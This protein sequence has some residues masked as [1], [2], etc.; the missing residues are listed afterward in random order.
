MKLLLLLIGG[1][2]FMNQTSFSD[3]KIYTELD[4][5]K[6]TNEQLAE[7]FI[8]QMEKSDDKILPKWNK[9]IEL[10]QYPE[11]YIKFGIKWDLLPEKS[12]YQYMQDLEKINININI[13]NFN[14]AFLA[15]DYINENFN[16][17]NFYTKIKS[18]NYK[19]VDNPISHPTDLLQKVKNSIK[20][21]QNM[22]TLQLKYD[23]MDC[24][25]DFYYN[26][27]HS[28]NYIIFNISLKDYMKH[29]YFTHFFQKRNLPLAIT[30]ISYPE[31]Y[32]TDDLYNQLFLKTCFAVGLGAP[33][34]QDF[35]DQY[36]IPV[37]FEVADLM[38]KVLYDP[39]LKGYPTRE[40]I[41]SLFNHW[42]Y[43]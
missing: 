30:P 19:E 41:L 40:N 39:K 5:A 36:G 8:T 35:L 34:G 9:P 13:K 28:I 7:Y 17:I 23:W 2:V 21:N 43:Q 26:Q 37:S 32:P 11:S 4:K 33:L 14:D 29:Y 16:N 38:V 3:D 31:Q 12:L 6:I 24:I 22:K 25:I 18:I 20:S 10:G 27:N 1:M 15:L 42:R